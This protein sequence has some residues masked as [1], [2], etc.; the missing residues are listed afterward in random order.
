MATFHLVAL[1]AFLLEYYNLVSFHVVEDLGLNHSA[2]HRRRTHGN[3]V[4]MIYEEHL[5]KLHRIAYSA[6]QPVNVNPLVLLNFELLPCYL[7][8]YVHLDLLYV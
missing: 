7:Y 4:V 1:T 2:R 6:S 8:Y 3:G 5:V